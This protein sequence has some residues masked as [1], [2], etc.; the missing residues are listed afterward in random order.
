MKLGMNQRFG[1]G[2][3]KVSRFLPKLWA[4]VGRSV[5]SVAFIK[6]VKIFSSFH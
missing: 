1:F 5:D 4:A 3:N 2:R 6:V